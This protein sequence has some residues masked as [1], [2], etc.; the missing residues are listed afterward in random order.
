MIFRGGGGAGGP[1]SGSA[2]AKDNQFP[3]YEPLRSKILAIQVI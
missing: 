3:K 2:Q 1:D